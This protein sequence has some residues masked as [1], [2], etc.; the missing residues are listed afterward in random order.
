MRLVIEHPL[1][2][3]NEYINAER[4]NK[5]RAAKIK[6]QATEMIAWDA[7]SQIKTE[8][9]FLADYTFYWTLP[10]KRKDPDNVSFGQKFIFDGLMMAGKLPNDSMK[11]VRS[12]CHFFDIGPAGV[13][14][15]IEQA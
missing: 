2:T 1:P 3:L 14:V 7:K 10:N 8:I 4:S 11:Y 6:K 9:D 12:I 5:F 15:E 13:T